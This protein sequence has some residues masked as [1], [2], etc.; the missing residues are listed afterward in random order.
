MKEI[1]QLCKSHHVPI[2]IDGAHAVGQINLNLNEIG[3]D[4]YC[5]NIHKVLIYFIYLYIHKVLIYQ[6]YFLLF[7]KKKIFN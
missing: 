2:M 5:S 6:I 3:A 7:E 1:I 4:F